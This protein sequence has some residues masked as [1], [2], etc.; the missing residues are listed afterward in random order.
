[1]TKTLGLFDTDPAIVNLQRFLNEKLGMKLKPDGNIGKITQSALATWQA[2]AGITETN[3]RGACYGPASQALVMPFC[4]FKYLTPSDFTNNAKLIN[5]EEAALR[6]VTAVEAK[7]F[8]FLEDGRPVILFERH[9]FY[10]QL[11]KTKGQAAAD[12][13]A[14]A[15]PDIC[16]RSTGGYLGGADEYKRYN[17]AVAIDS[18]SAKM[19][20]SWGLFQ[21]MGFNFAQAGYKTVEAYV[22]A[23]VVSED[24]QLAAFCSYIKNDRDGTLLRALQKRM[25]A[26]FANE[27]NGPGY[28]V[29]KYDTK[30]QAGYDLGLTQSVIKLTQNLG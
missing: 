1:M 9:I 24:L 23:M 30:M 3:D 8:G 28:A 25:W 7:Q 29:N 26:A 4:E 13:I 21:I 14:S 16:N 6:A 27:Y 18:T 19:S 22:D 20:T 12:A 10:K 17:R 2:N 11:V 15:N 5:I